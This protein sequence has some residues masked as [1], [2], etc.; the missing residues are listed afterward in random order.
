VPTARFD[1]VADF[2]VAGWR[3]QYDDAVS[4]ALFNLLEPLRA[5]QVLDLAC[6][7]GR[8]SRELARRGAQVVGLDLSGAMLDRARA[9][10]A[11]EGLEIRYVQ[12]DAASPSVLEG[13][14]FDTVVCSFGLSDIDDLDGAIATV[15]RVLAPAG[16][17]VFSLLHPCFA[18]GAEVSGAWRSSGS[19]YDEGWWLPDG[20]LSS[21]RRQV[22]TNHRMLSTYV[23]TLRRYG[24]TIDHLAEP[25]PPDAWTAQRADTAGLPVFL[26]AR[27]KLL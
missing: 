22:G 10:E 6:G 20:A 25:G 4:V 9:I 19:Y 8:I 11:R 27:A 14:V 26:V 15:A 3:D 7:H 12:G 13:E 24:L 1:S 23:N 5:A 2:Y 18:G 16:S 17:F 21:L